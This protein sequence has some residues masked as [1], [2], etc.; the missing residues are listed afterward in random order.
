MA[1]YGSSIMREDP[2]RRKNM[3]SDPYKILGVSENATKEEIK[4][5]YRKKAKEYHPDMHPDDPDA[6]R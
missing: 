2:R 5:A 6:E 3:I 1:E 4:N